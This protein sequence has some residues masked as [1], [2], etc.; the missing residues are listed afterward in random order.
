MGEDR[1]LTA[2]FTYGFHFEDAAYS[3]YLRDHAL[4]QGVRALSASLAEVRCDESGSILGLR[5]DDGSEVSAD[6]YLDC[7]GPDACLLTR[8][9]PDGREDWSGSLPCN[10]MWSALGPPTP[11][12]PAVTQTVA[13][14][15]GWL[16]RAPLAQSC[17]VGH[18]FSSGFQGEADAL[19][20]LA[21]FE[22]GI[23]GDPQL[24]RFS[25][26]RRRRFW[27][28]NC[29]VIG[30]AAVELEPLAGADLHIALL[31]L[32][33][34]IELFPRDRESTVE[35]A[36]YDRIMAEHAY[37]LRDFTL[38]HYRAG[39]PRAG[40][41][42]EAVRAQ[43]LP[44]RLA[45]KLELYASNGRIQLL[46]HESFEE[47]DWAWLLIGSGCKLEALELQTRAQL[48]KLAPRD[49]TALRT[50]V[51]QVAASM[52]PHMEFVRRQ[53]TLSARSAR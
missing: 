20:A 41:F 26:G 45:H 50:H 16:W 12:P 27:Q 5:L 48:A 10:R 15:A 42:W 52:P 32:A 30:S 13:T 1:S 51:Q 3:N 31:G 49:V 47:A 46:D 40:E 43:E 9:E 39:A 18:V 19:A 11:E 28:R 23:R 38:A 25:A 8:I 22:P 6:Y 53:A 34:F 14:Q 29:V 24:A 17:M 36:E 21:A 37:A 33:T 7:S 4:R 44:A 2:S 35:A